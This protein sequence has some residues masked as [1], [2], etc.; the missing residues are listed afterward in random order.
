MLTKRLL[1]AI[2]TLLLIV[3]LP[4]QVNAA[5]ITCP[6]GQMRVGNRCVIAI[7]PP[8]NDPPPP[9]GGKPG[10][11]PKVCR[12]D[13]GA[14]VPCTSEMGVWSNA[15]LCYLKLLAPQ[16]PLTAPWWDG[17]TPDEG[18]IYDCTTIDREMPGYYVFIPNGG[19][20]VDVRAIAERLRAEMPVNP[21]EIG[22]VPEPGPESVGLV[23][24]P[25]WMWVADPGPTTWGPQSRSLTVGGITVTLQARVETI[26]WSMGDGAV[27]SC[28]SP[29]TPYEDPLRKRGLAHL[30]TPIH[31]ARHLPRHGYGLLDRRMVGHHRGVRQLRVADGLR[32]LDQCG[33]SPS[34]QPVTGTKD[35]PDDHHPHHFFRCC[36]GER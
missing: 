31:E 17:H 3:G 25:T 32:D 13:G 16:P 9:G 8:S 15:R 28:S 29:G 1:P 10:V 2:L 36:R 5:E 21:V 24:L 26:R 7:D 34:P 22:I 20:E 27:V 33:R 35:S 30:R 14:V 4:L 18:A 11:A 6:E 23:G 19:E 12:R